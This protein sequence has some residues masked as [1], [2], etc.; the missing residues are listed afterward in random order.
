MR[1]PSSAAIGSTVAAGVAT[2]AG[3]RAAG[4]T[5]PAGSEQVLDHLLADCLERGRRG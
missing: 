4:R 5:R 1:R 3:T 2:G